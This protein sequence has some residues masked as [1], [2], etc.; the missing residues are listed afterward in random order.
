MNYKKIA[1]AAG[2]SVGTVSKAFSYSKEI[3]EKTRAKIFA[4]AK[5]AG[6]LEKYT[7][8]KYEKHVIAVLCPEIVSQYYAEMVSILDGIIK[9]NGDMMMMSITNFA[10]DTAAGLY[11]YYQKYARVDGILIIASHKMFAAQSQVPTV[12]LGP[13]PETPGID[14]V[15]TSL[16]GAVYEAIRYLKDSNRRRIAFIGETLTCSKLAAYET[17]LL[18]CGI[19]L[20]HDL[21]VVSES[22]FEAAGYDGAERLLALTEP[23]DAIITAYDYIAIGAIKALKKHGLTVPEDVSIIG[24]DDISLASY[25]DIP[26]TTIKTDL[27][28]I[29]ETAAR[30]LY[31]KMDNQYYFS[32]EENI[33][34]GELVIRESVADRKREK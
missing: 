6:V 8:A 5:E 1:E 34:P 3:S 30:L 15:E 7:R 21:I 27:T 23:P 32:R 13:S 4:V 16:A 18:K 14:A 11:D 22:R 26:L 12:V 19:P 31:K 24:M 20:S 25:L 17:A 9:S 2:V 28:E 33:I 29:C 10:G